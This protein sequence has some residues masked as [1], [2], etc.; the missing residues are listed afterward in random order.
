ML[1]SHRYKDSER[2]LT[3]EVRVW[4]REHPELEA[5]IAVEFVTK[6][7]MVAAIPDGEDSMGRQK[8]RLGTTDEMVSRATDCAAF[9]VSEL[10]RLKWLHLTPSMIPEEKEADNGGS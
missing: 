10:R 1:E 9:L 3:P 8:L 6:W 7:G 4:D 5:K 2:Y